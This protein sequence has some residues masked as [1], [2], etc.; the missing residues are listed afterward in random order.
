MADIP[1]FTYFPAPLA[2]DCMRLE[3][4]TCPCCQEFRPHLY[5]GDMYHQEE[6]EEVCLWCISDGRAAK[7]W[8]ATFNS[9]CDAPSGFSESILDIITKRTPG[10]MSWQGPNWLFSSN[11]AMVFTGEVNGK[12]LLKENNKSKIAACLHALRQWHGN[13]PEESLNQIGISTDPAVYLFQDRDTGAYRAYAD[14]P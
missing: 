12:A 3:P 1:T 14:R 2:N 13:W 8:G 6:H 7:Q 5:V 11:D 10:Y 4:G 9:A